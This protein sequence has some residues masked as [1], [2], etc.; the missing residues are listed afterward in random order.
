[1]VWALW[2][3][4]TEIIFFSISSAMNLTSICNHNVTEIKKNSQENNQEPRRFFQTFG[5]QAFPKLDIYALSPYVK[6]VRA[7]FRWKRLP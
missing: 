1:M 7:I 2:L 6:L 5:A 3:V 4:L